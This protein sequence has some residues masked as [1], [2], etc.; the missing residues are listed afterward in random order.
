M[1]KLLEC[2]VG[3]VVD[4]TGR[5]VVL[6]LKNRPDYL[7]GLWIGVAGKIEEGETPLQAMRREFLEEAGVDVPDWTFIKL[8][9][10]PEAPCNLHVFF[11]RHDVSKVKT[12][13]DETVR[14]FHFEDLCGMPFGNAFTEIRDQLTAWARNAAP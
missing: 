14:V 2:V 12:M 13:T 1:D 7:D 11:A 3:Y 6:L 8:L 5:R 10:N 4:P 9:D